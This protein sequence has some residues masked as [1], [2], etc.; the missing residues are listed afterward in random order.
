MKNAYKILYA[1]NGI[2]DRQ[3]V[4][5]KEFLKYGESDK[6]I[7]YRKFMRTMLIAAIIACLLTITA[8]AIGYTLHQ[9]RQAEIREEFKIEENNVSGYVEYSE[10]EQETTNAVP[11]ESIDNTPHVQLIA[12]IDNGKYQRIFL[13][14]S[15]VSENVL[16]GTF[17]TGN[18]D[19][20]DYMI[21]A[22][23]SN[24]P[25]VE[26]AFEYEARGEEIPFDVE[27]TY[28]GAHYTLSEDEELEHQIM[29]RDPDTDTELPM[30]D[31]NYRW[32]KIQNEAYDSETQSLM[33]ECTIYKGNIDW[34]KTVYAAVRLLDL[35]SI[36]IPL[37][38]VFNSDS[39]TVEEWNRTHLPVYLD[40]Y[41]VA[42][43]NAAEAN[44]V[45]FNLSAG[46]IEFENPANDGTLKVLGVVV[47]PTLVEITVS[48]NDIDEIF[49][50]PEGNDTRFREVFEKQ[51]QWVNFYDELLNNSE[52]VFSNGTAMPLSPSNS[53]QYEDGNVTLYS[54]FS[55]TVDICKVTGIRIM[56][57]FIERK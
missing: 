43:L 7:D 26:T 47:K 23:A 37:E 57:R 49:N 4:E 1:M 40:D 36:K 6:R 34:T 51:I 16:E 48:H 53:V 29:Y 38:L 5:T 13:S 11:A 12:S 41:G 25:D 52:L 10:N 33:I 45:S 22:F 28:A 18:V 14:I 30:L 31:P 21:A 27:Y 20:Q 19:N 55:S 42:E 32:Q 24:S 50:L 35:N 3:I 15:P 56:E 54:S 44:S 17:R 46:Q 2:S 39:E 8:F 9:L